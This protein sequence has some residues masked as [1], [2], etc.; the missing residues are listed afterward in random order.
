MN[1]VKTLVLSLFLLAGLTSCSLF[2][3][4]S[5]SAATNS[6]ENGQASSTK[7][8]TE[9]PA[10]SSSTSSAAE[11]EVQKAAEETKNEFKVE[12]FAEFK[13][14]EGQTMP[15]VVN[16]TTTSDGKDQ[17]QVYAGLVR[18]VPVQIT[19]SFFTDKKIDTY[20]FS[21][22][23]DDFHSSFTQTSTYVYR[24]VY[25]HSKTEGSTSYA[26]EAN[27]STT[28]SVELSAGVTVGYL[29]AG[30]STSGSHTDYS[31]I[32]SSR[33]NS[34]SYENASTNTHEYSTFNQV[35][36]QHE[37]KTAV[38]F[39]M[40]DI[41][42][43]YYRYGTF[44]DCD[45]YLYAQVYVRDSVLVVDDL[46]VE[47]S[48]IVAST[49]KGID[50]TTDKD[51]YD[52]G[53]LAPY[54][55]TETLLKNLDYTQ[56]QK[57]EDFPAPTQATPANYFT[58]KDGVITSFT[59]RNG[60]FPEVRV[61]GVIDGNVITAIGARAFHGNETLRYVYLPS[62]IK[63]I[64]SDAF[65]NCT[66]LARVEMGSDVETLDSGAFS[67]CPHLR[68][69]N[70]PSSLKSVSRKVFDG[71]GRLSYTYEDGVFYLTVGDNAHFLLVRAKT[72]I[73]KLNIHKD[74]KI[75]AGEAFKGCNTNEELDVKL[76]EGLISVGPSAFSGCSLQ[77][78]ALPSTMTEIGECA[79]EGAKYLKS[80]TIPSSITSIGESA[81]KGCSALTGAV[82]LE[83][84]TSIGAEAFYGCGI[85]SIEVRSSLMS[86]ESEAFYG[87][88]SLASVSL[89]NTVTSIG[90][91]AFYGCESLTSLAI[92]ASVTS[93]DLSAVS[94]CS[95]LESFIVDAGNKTYFSDGKVLFNKDKTEL[96]A[97][98][99]RAIK[100]DYAI[101]SSVT[102]IDE[103]A[104]E[105]CKSLASINIPDSVTIVGDNAFYG[106]EALTSI[107]IPDSVTSVG[108]SA[109]S[110]CK[111]LTSVEIPS[112]ITFI[113][114]YLFFGCESLASVSLP[115][116]VTSIGEDAFSG[117]K[118]LASISIPASV[119]SIG[120]WAFYGCESLTSLAIPASV[121]SFPLS[122]VSGCSK[123]E[124][125][126]VDAGNK[127]Y[128][129]DG[130]VLFN[131][132]KTV[133]I[134][135]IR[136][137]KGDYTIPS[138][139]T[140][141]G[142]GA[143]YGCEALTSIN[144][145]DS[146]TS[147]GDSAF[148]RCKALTGVVIPGSI[149][150]I[151]RSAFYDCSSLTQVTLPGT[152][153]EICGCAFDFCP[154]LTSITFQGTKNQFWAIKGYGNIEGYG[155]LSGLT[156]VCTDGMVKL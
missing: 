86:I 99:A 78:I 15:Y 18:R 151:P 1:K 30:I 146:V 5:S 38:S 94:G 81:F 4:H 117:C 77:S 132:D 37:I 31:G 16:T 10:S 40:S 20:S 134:D 127:T 80:V 70:L 60:A 110:C 44:V 91:E 148:S 35:L 75:I 156:I 121:T 149:K 28:H 105:R 155:N 3:S 59:D 46:S 125:L 95:K 43:G 116:T 142:D 26:A 61:P 129:S 34:W 68:Y 29:N 42:P 93:F 147:V 104:F 79:F 123:L 52:L 145:P 113:S 45:M 114:Y 41:E 141:V 23:T 53:R 24:S 13:N 108:K 8:S 150:V 112:S 71:D 131:K 47:F 62:T 87:C 118:A 90:S 39:S 96:F 133:L 89:P 115:N 63:S 2:T 6:S 55:I 109:F 137:I 56:Q 76:P 72:G 135:A 136:T 120:N 100:G 122:A 128:S 27:Q 103:N 139:V 67:G 106:C 19:D 92:P 111:S 130:K 65:E 69:L 119:I 64:G 25:S 97:C 88:E 22:S 143:F 154:K 51:F 124:S 12:P 102:S 14:K 49:M 82:I 98:V 32:T 21:Y 17:Y 7:S 84:V 36:D 107:N 153:T 54:D 57:Y 50:Y 83:S 144:I 152:L 74:T 66:H 140:S 138:S 73:L 33:S 48:P 58:Y 9:T 126:T 101:P 11:T 85:T